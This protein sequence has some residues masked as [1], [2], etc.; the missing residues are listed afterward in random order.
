MIFAPLES[1]GSVLRKGVFRANFPCTFSSSLPSLFIG[2]YS[3]AASSEVTSKAPNSLNCSSGKAILPPSIL[4]SSLLIIKALGAFRLRLKAPKALGIEK[5]PSSSI[6]FLSS[7]S[8]PNSISNPAIVKSSSSTLPVSV[9]EPKTGV[10]KGR[11]KLP[12]NRGFSTLL[13]CA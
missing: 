13:I 5:L 4:M 6:W 12:L 10:S 11:V 7:L 9:T 8:L 1:L 3:I 2:V